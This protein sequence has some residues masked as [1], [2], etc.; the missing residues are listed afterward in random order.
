M[1][2]IMLSVFCSL[3]SVYCWWFPSVFPPFTLSSLLLLCRISLIALEKGKQ[4][5][6]SLYG[7]VRHDASDRIDWRHGPRPDCTRWSQLL[8]LLWMFALFSLTRSRL[9]PVLPKD[10]SLLPFF[11]LCWRH[12]SNLVFDDNCSMTYDITVPLCYYVICVCRLLSVVCFL[13]EKEREMST[14]F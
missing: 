4:L 12:F 8:M 1:S 3:S 7:F 11:F 2:T 9:L 6:S 10:I 5:G 13:L 14:L